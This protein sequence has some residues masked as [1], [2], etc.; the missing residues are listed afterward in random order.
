ML[1]SEFIFQQS[2][3]NAIPS[4]KDFDA[5]DRAAIIRSRTK[6][7]PIFQSIEKDYKQLLATDNLTS[8]EAIVK[9]NQDL[10]EFRKKL[11]KETVDFEPLKLSEETFIAICG[12]IKSPVQVD[13][14]IDKKT[15]PE[16]DFLSYFYQHLVN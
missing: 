11:V 5:K 13:L 16:D 12:L 8:A 15:V 4:T 10:V 9:H 1:K 3:L 2:L 6:G 7:N 14:I